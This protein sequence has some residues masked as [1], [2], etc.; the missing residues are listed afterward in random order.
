[1]NATLLSGARLSNPFGSNHGKGAWAASFFPT[2]FQLDKKSQKFSKKKPRRVELTRKAN[3]TFDTDAPNDYL[4]R[5]KDRG[6]YEV[7]VDGLKV[8][9]KHS[10]HGS[11]GVWHLNFD[12]DKS[13]SV[14]QVIEIKLS[15]EDVSK[16]SPIEEKFWVEVTQF[17]KRSGGSRINIKK[18]GQKGSGNNSTSSHSQLPP[19]IEVK[20]GDSNWKNFG[21]SDKDAFS[22]IKHEAQYDIYINM[23][24]LYLNTE[25]KYSKDQSD[26]ILV[27]TCYKSGLVIQALALAFQDT[28]NQITNFEEHV[29]VQSLSMA[30]TIIPLTK[31]LAK[32]ISI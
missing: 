31:D 10:L 27:E 2:Y 21:W 11:E 22:L 23:D 15:V 29:R 25:Q 6:S 17:Q 20:Q 30:P 24:N 32:S 9:N 4:S 1:M 28:Q 7:Y 16:P 26:K 12:I 14:G 3:F 18:K 8:L 5:S 13:Y 19:I